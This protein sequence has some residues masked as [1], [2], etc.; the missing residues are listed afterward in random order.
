MAWAL[1]EGFRLAA[2]H[3]VAFLGSS[4]EIGRLHDLLSA[5]RKHFKMLRAAPEVIC[6]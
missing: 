4:G 1:K 2:Q 5:L 3:W 6:A